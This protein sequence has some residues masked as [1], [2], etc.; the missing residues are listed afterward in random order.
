MSLLNAILTME[1]EM[2]FLVWKIC[3]LVMARH[4]QKKSEDQYEREF[5]EKS[6]EPYQ[7]FLLQRLQ[8]ERWRRFS[9]LDHF[10]FWNIIR[11]LASLILQTERRIKEDIQFIDQRS[12][13]LSMTNDL[14]MMSGV[15]R[16]RENLSK[17]MEEAKERL[18]RSRRESERIQTNMAK[19]MFTAPY[20]YLCMIRKLVLRRIIQDR[21]FGVGPP[22]RIFEIEYPPNTIM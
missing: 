4:W 1:M 11:G 3:S 22:Q 19:K 15:E 21:G 8:R 18:L 9:R 13:C 5:W 7:V 17:E 20:P 12:F 10:Q 16:L 2:V 6:W 14:E